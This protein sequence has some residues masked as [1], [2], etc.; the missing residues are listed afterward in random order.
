[1]S[2][3]LAGCVSCHTGDASRTFSKRLIAS[4]SQEHL[5]LLLPHGEFAKIQHSTVKGMYAAGKGGF[6]GICGFINRSKEKMEAALS[7][8]FDGPEGADRPRD[9]EGGAQGSKPA[10]ISIESTHAPRGLSA[11]GFDCVYI[12]RLL[13]SRVIS[14]RWRVGATPPPSSSSQ[15][16]GENTERYQR[17]SNQAK[18]H[19]SS[20]LEIPRRRARLRCAAEV[21]KIM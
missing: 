10:R 12:L 13:A 17:H 2:G 6:S 9:G 8:T 5:L 1:M 4:D 16:I 14:K 7:G 19:E 18:G 11:K 20:T 21:Q 15:G 3:P